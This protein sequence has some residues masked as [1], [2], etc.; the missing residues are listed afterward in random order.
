M[1]K[2]KLI[3][4]LLTCFLGYSQ[5]KLCLGDDARAV[6]T[7]PLVL[8][9]TYEVVYDLSG[10]NTVTNGRVEIVFVNGIGNL[11]IPSSDFSQSGITILKVI[12]MSNVATECYSLFPTILTKNF[13]TKDFLNLAIENEYTF[14]K[15]KNKRL[16]D[17]SDK[18][19]WYDENKQPLGSNEILRTGTYYYK[20]ATDDGCLSVEF[21]STNVN[22][23]SC[24][25][26]IPNAFSPNNDNFNDTFN[27][28]NIVDKYPNYEI[29]IVNRHGKIVYMGKNGWNGTFNNKGGEILENGVYYLYLDYKDSSKV[30][31]KSTILLQK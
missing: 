8:D 6:I 26:L 5:E 14:C 11:S 17:L 1:K 29:T 24:E 22:I 4:I 2:I 28:V 31:T 19:Q 12:G 18:T 23:Q 13:E 9:G 16:S 15:D 27:V 21:S 30:N 3:I 10:A 25:L 20:N 7:A